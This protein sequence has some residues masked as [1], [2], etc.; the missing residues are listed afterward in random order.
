M[1]IEMVQNLQQLLDKITCVE[2]LKTELDQKQEN[3]KQAH[4]RVPCAVENFD[5]ENKEKFIVY[6]IGPAPAKPKGIIRLAVPLYKKKKR[7]FEEANKEYCDKYQQVEKEYYEKYAN[8]RTKLESE[9]TAEIS[10]N[11]K[12]TE[13]EFEE[14]QYN[15]LI[16]V[17]NLNEDKTLSDK[18]KR[19]EVVTK[20]LEYFE[21]QRVDSYKEAINLYYEEEHR[22]KLENF[23]NEQVRLTN[24]AKKYALDAAERAS[25]AIDQAKKAMER[26]DD[27]YDLADDAYDR[28]DEAYYEAQNR[29]DNYYN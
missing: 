13:K 27:A 12:K 22:L 16:A 1:E 24:E 19:I 18:L 25:E 5:K 7:A 15:Y 6:R 17:R 11:I 28:A 10:Y 9:E 8:K 23:A 2:M 4:S 3:L 21:E 29:N 20:L 26:A 14:V